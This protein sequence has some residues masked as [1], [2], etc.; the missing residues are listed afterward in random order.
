MMVLSF[1]RRDNAI[2]NSMTQKTE[3]PL[4]SEME[5]LLW[6]MSSILEK[7]CICRTFETD[8][9]ELIQVIQTSDEWSALTIFL[10]RFR[11][12]ISQFLHFF[13]F[14]FLLC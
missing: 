7:W 9:S 3:V 10:E 8:C 11:E 12:F 1:K 4:Y 6:K 14:D 13:V 5:D 2:R